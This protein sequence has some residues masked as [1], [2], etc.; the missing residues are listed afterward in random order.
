[1]AK[2]S[3]F[4]LSVWRQAIWFHCLFLLTIMPNTSR[5]FPISQDLIDEVSGSSIVWLRDNV[6]ADRVSQIAKQFSEANK[7][8]VTDLYPALKGFGIKMAPDQAQDFLSKNS[9]QF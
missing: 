6:D 7:V 2:A 8:T 9:D 1:M 3:S 4:T 5:A